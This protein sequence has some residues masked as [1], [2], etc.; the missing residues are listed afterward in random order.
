MRRGTLYFISMQTDDS[1]TE[2]TNDFITRCRCSH[3]LFHSHR[4]QGAAQLQVAALALVEVAA[5]AAMLQVP[6]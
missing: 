1:W 2:R 5:A 6:R 4:S 3:Y